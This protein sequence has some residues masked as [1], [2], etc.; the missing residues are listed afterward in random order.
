MSS[1]PITDAQPW[2]SHLFT[3]CRGQSDSRI[4]TGEDYPTRALSTLW[5]MAPDSKP[6]AS[7]L[8][9][10]PSSYSDYDARSHEAQ[11]ARGSFVTLAADIDGGNHSADAVRAVV[12]AFAGDAAWLI[13]TS[14]H[15][16]PGDTRWRVIVPLAAAVPFDTWYDAQTALFS[17][18]DARGIE[19]DRA[20]SR[21][22][23][24]V[25]LP[26]VP[27]VHKTGT[28]LRNEQGEPLYFERHAT[29][30]DA[31]GL[32]LDQGPVAQGIAAI[33]RQRAIDE[34]ERQRLKAEAEKRRAARPAGNGGSL[35]DD[36]NAAN[37]IAD[38]LLSC[39]YE[40]S[41][42][43]DEDYRSPNQTGDTYATRVMGSKWVSL[44]GSDAAAGLGE[45]CA[46]GCY[47]DAF[48]L[49]VFYS[50][51]NNRT[52]ALR[53]LG[54]ERR[55]DNVIYPAQFEAEP[56]EWMA[57]IPGFEPDQADGW[58]P[59]YSGEAYLELAGEPVARPNSSGGKL[60]FEWAGQTSPVLDGL[61][62]IDDW[63]PKSGIAAVYGHPGSGKSFLV[64]DMAAHV[65]AGQPW[66]GRHTEQG[67]VVYVVAEGQTG[68]RNRL[69]AMQRDGKIAPDA[70]FVFIPTPI[71][72]QA[73]D[74]DLAA[75]METI[76][77]VAEQARV[78]IAMLIIDTLSKTFGAGKENTDDMAG[79]V[80]NC[81]RVSSAFDCLT[82]VVHHRPKDS[83]SRDLRGHSSLRG[84]I[85]TTILVESGD[86][87]TATTLKQKDGEDNVVVRFKLD[88]VVI[89]EDKRGKEIST[90]LTSIVEGH[91]DAP[92]MHPKDAR[93]RRL[94]GHKRMALKVI[95]EVIDRDGRDPPAGIPAASIDRYR[96]WKAVS[97][98]LVR[99]RLQQ[100]FLALSDN[101]GSDPSD[102][103]GDKTSDNAR[104]N[105]F[106]VLKDLKA[107][108]ILGS[109]GEW[110]WIN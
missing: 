33:R 91:V 58:E 107:A 81:Q 54:A 46:A 51:S 92:A 15:S 13:Y 50:H 87:K 55:A 79:Y 45:K 80:A 106:R 104:R 62:L 41:P 77:H 89:G 108:E 97:A 90:C 25:Y 72:M 75:L 6:K 27:P 103:G 36:F 67:L 63:L 69:F 98:T 84:G 93:K 35:I 96:T 9:M 29:P 68:F 17:F 2:H 23:Q 38:M 12:E 105:M 3:Y 85:E 57:E 94:T 102:K 64:L 99:D 40:Q 32:A 30:M 7:G 76:Y 61:W 100:E 49:F 26:N 86:I 110:F 37:S 42:R 109:Y 20:L 39:G 19:T 73:P 70:P 5:T 65:A 8:A 18:L 59:D 53:Q 1:L 88:R 48:D 22:G 16:R 78:P 4:K 11:R 31:P 71:D 47:G 44:S 43:H 52:N 28:P 74:G 34:K 101:G 82:V 83:E 14:A 10:I 56:P 24:L 60:P 95:E 66:A 21:A